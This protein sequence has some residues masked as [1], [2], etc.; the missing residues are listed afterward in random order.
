MAERQA[1]PSQAIHYSPW[2]GA[3]REVMHEAP[4]GGGPRGA[5]LASPG[6]GFESKGRGGSLRGSSWAVLD[7]Q[8][9]GL[10]GFYYI[11][12]KKSF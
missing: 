2:L 10:F 4:L 5:G 6:S 1:H 3:G 11:S 9:L 8:L 12:L 7:L